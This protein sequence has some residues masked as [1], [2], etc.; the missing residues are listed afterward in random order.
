MQGDE[1]DV[2]FKNP[3]LQE[4][5]DTLEKAKETSPSVELRN[6]NTMTA[7]IRKTEED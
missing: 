2:S 5:S 6:N 3:I 1:E 7:E 4:G